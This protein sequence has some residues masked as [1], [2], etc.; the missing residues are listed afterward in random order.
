MNTAFETLA[1]FRTAE[2]E[3][4]LT[5]ASR[6]SPDSLTRLSRLRKRHAAE[7]SAGAVQLLELR[8]RAEAKFSDAARMFF[9]REGLEQS[10]GETIAAYRAAR[11]PLEGVTLDACCGIGGDALALARSRPV[12]AVDL[13]PAHALCTRTN[14][15]ILQVSHSVTALV[16][17]VTELNFANLK[18][19]GI[20]SVFF[21]PSRRG[22]SAGGERKRMRGAED[23]SP[24]LSWATALREAFSFV[25]V[26]L[27]PAL[28]DAALLNFAAPVE[29]ISE[30]GECKEAVLWLCESEPP[31]EAKG[32]GLFRA[33]VLKP[34]QPPS[35]LTF[36][37]TEPVPASEILTY[38]YEPDPAVIRAGLIPQLAQEFLLSPVNLQRVLLTAENKIVTPFTAAYQVRET[39]PYH[40]E[41]LKRHLKSRGWRVEVV[42]K[43]GVEIEPEALRRQLNAGQSDGEGVTLFLF[44]QGEKRTGVICDLYPRNF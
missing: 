3:A 18:R 43:R 36:F 25:A 19:C 6:L 20:T 30:R 4:L 31:P 40:P 27:S 10:T 8:K 11:F 1:F 39:L 23:Y 21:D 22:T 15:E 38:L 2:G 16:S 17:D 12:L 13:N 37:Q 42:K 7:L 29:F 28:D 32:G 44:R 14:G 33:T 24:P 26:K 41:K 9:T 5:E 35:T 34:G